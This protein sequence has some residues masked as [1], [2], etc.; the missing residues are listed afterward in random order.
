MQ[1]VEVVEDLTLLLVEVVEEQTEQED[2]VAVEML[3]QQELLILVVEV[4]E[5]QD[6]L[7]QD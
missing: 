4:A 2:P 7:V 5:F 3:D 6:H 1:V